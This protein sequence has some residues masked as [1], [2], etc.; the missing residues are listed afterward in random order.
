MLSSK[1]LN[2]TRCTFESHMKFR[3]RTNRGDTLQKP[4]RPNGRLRVPLSVPTRGVFNVPLPQAS[5]NGTRETK[6]HWP[7]LVAQIAGNHSH[8]C[9]PPRRLSTVFGQFRL[10]WP[11]S[12]LLYHRIRPANRAR[13][14]FGK[15][16]VL[17]VLPECWYTGVLRL[18]LSLCWFLA[19]LACVQVARTSTASLSSFDST[20][21][22]QQSNTLSKHSNAL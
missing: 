3:L 7:S 11:T 14:G 13:S 20:G 16:L 15:F 17:G 8:G 21:L 6:G 12:R 10:T 5:T 4:L 19:D 9:V 22:Q 2:F 1:A 18:R